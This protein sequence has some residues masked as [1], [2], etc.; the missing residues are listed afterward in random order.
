MI[1]IIVHGCSKGYDKAINQKK[2]PE[3]STK[4]KYHEVITEGEFEGLKIGQSKREALKAL[5]PQGVT[6]VYR[7]Y[8]R[9][10]SDKTTVR[11]DFNNRNEI[12]KLHDKKGFCLL[13]S[14]AL[15]LQL[16]FN[17]SNNLI[18]L[19]SSPEMKAIKH[20]IKVGQSKPEVLRSL[21]KL[22]DENKTI[23]IKNCISSFNIN[24]QKI[25]EEEIFFISHYDLWTFHIAEIKIAMQENIS[26]R[27]GDFPPRA[28]ER[29]DLYFSGN[30]LKKIARHHRSNHWILN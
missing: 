9:N 13:G 11:I 3:V 26:M 7:V 6:K 22:I 27:F 10:S 1:F 14:K 25:T 15:N 17:D 16:E 30:S 20:G 5:A 29:I 23:R 4:N 18:I 21:R 8:E 12:H 28:F 19:D 24:P 2:Y